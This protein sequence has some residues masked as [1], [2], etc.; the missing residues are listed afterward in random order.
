MGCNI[1]TLCGSD[2]REITFD[3]SKEGYELC[4]EDWE[5]SFSVAQDFESLVPLEAIGFFPIKDAKFHKLQ[6]SDS[7]VLESQLYHNT[8]SRWVRY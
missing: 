7:C 1:I 8:E 3:I 6:E 5:S 4:E 2:G